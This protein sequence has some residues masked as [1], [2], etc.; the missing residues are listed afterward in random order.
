MFKQIAALLRKKPVETKLPPFPVETPVKK[1]PVK[2]ELIKKATTR[3]LAAKKVAVK[4]TA[5]KK[6]K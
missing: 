2:K 5:P 6:K 3:K 4:K 1:E